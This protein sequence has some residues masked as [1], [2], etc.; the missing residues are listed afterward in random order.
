MQFNKFIVIFVGFFIV[1][2]QVVFVV[3][4]IGVVFFFV[5]FGY[6]EVSDGVWYKNKIDFFKGDSFCNFDYEY[7]NKILENF[8][9]VFDCWYMYNN[10]KELGNWYV[11][12]YFYF[13]IDRQID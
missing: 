11:L 4:E 5:D 8:F 6:I 9:L 7:W 2:I 12:L 13:L 10:I 1:V 3:F